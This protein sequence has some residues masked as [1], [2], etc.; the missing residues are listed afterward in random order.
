MNDLKLTNNHDLLIEEGDLVL[1]NNEA[2]M[3]VQSLKI[4]LLLFRGEWFLDNTIGVPYFQE[5]LGKVSNK[6]LVDNII[7]GIS[8][9]SYN[10]YRVTGL[11]S[12][13]SEDRV[14]EVNLLEALT[15]DGEIISVTNLQV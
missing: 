4:N 6:T 1:I 2:E 12:S 13:I 10:I 7:K 11:N 15:E 8:T 3:A 9:N 14:Y 5:I